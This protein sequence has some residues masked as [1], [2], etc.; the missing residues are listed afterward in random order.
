ML[1]NLHH[2]NLL[3]GT[4]E[5]GESYLRSLCSNLGIEPKNNPDFTVFRT[6]TFGV[7]EARELRLLSLRKP[8]TTAK[9]G[10]AGRKIF[11]ILPTKLTPEAQNALLKTFEDPTPDTY[12]FLVLRE[13]G[14]L[15]PTL[16]SRM[17]TTRIS[18]MFA[19]DALAEEF[20][21]ASLKERLLFAECFAD[22]KENLSAFLDNLLIFLRGESGKEKSVEKVYKLR[23]EIL[24]SG[25]GSRLVLEHLAL[26]L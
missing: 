3:I 1:R 13:E 25:I 21:K 8:V 18:K 14:L 6:E 2:S 24:E 11:L 12:F 15:L 9:A 10:Q 20:F 19:T 4:P 26:V 22:K 16:R 5:E 17:Q 7:D 23:R